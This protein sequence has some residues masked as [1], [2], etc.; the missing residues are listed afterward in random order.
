MVDEEVFFFV[1]KFIVI[2]DGYIVLFVI[3]ILVVILEVKK[4]IEEYMKNMLK[5]LLYVE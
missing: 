1:R 5:F 2:R 4:M 3:N